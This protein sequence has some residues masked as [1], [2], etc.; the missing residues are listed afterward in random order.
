M[1]KIKDKE[2]EKLEEIK[3]MRNKKKLKLKEEDL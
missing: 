3:Y 1:K 2:K